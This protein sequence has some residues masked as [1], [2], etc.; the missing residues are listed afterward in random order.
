MRRLI[1]R[2]QNFKRAQWARTEPE[3]AALSQRLLS[4]AEQALAA[5]TPTAHPPEVSFQDEVDRLHQVWRDFDSHAEKD[6][7]HLIGQAAAGQLGAHAT[8][9]KLDSLRWIR[10]VSYHLWRILGH[11]QDASAAAHADSSNFG[12]WDMAD[13]MDQS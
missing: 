1:D 2:C 8:I 11:L 13:E 3:L 6:R 12:K 10:R 9:Q 7:Q 4:G 5:L